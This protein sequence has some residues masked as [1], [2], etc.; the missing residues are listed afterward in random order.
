M[1]EG[2]FDIGQRQIFSFFSLYTKDFV[3]KSRTLAN[4]K[5][6]KSTS[7]QYV[8]QISLG[9]SKLY[10]VATGEEKNISNKH[11]GSEGLFNM[12]MWFP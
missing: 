2:A 1:V 4:S 9:I 3:G 7:Y 12:T 11:M 5:L 6:G 8:V 10:K